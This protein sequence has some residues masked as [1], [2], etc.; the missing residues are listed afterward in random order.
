MGGILLAQPVVPAGGVVD[1]AAYSRE[2]APG[3]IVTIFGANLAPGFAPATELPLPTALAG[4]S[5]EISDGVKTVLMP[6][7]W[8]MPAQLAGQI[9]YDM[10]PHVTFRVLTGAGA[11]DPDSLMLAPRAPKLFSVSEEGVGRAVVLHLDGQGATRQ[12]PLKP[13][14]WV[15]LYANSLG[16]VDPP[17]MAGYGAGDGSPG[18]P[19]SEV[20]APVTAMIGGRPAIVAFAGL[21]PDLAGL[22]QLNVFTPY[23]DTIGD[24][25]V[26]VSAEG[27]ES[28]TGLSVPAEPN[29]FY[30]VIGAGKFPN[31]QTRN[32]VPGPGAAIVFM[33]DNVPIWGEDGLR[34]W[35]FSSPLGA[36]HAATSG[37]ALTL[38]NQGVVV[39]DN[40][41]IEDGTHGGFY[42]NS[43]GAVSDNEK[44]GLWEWY[45]MSNDL[46]GVFASYF[47]LPQ[48]TT[49][50]EIIGYFDGNGQ[51]ELRFN[52][53]SV[54]NRFRMNIWSNGAGEMPATNSFTGNVFSSDATPG[55]FSY[56][57][58]DARRIFSTGAGEPLYRMVYKLDQPL[59]LEAG[60]YWFSHDTAV[61][62]STP[63]AGA[64]TRA[65]AKGY[66]PAPPANAFVGGIE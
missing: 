6:L 21:T 36:A 43:N 52:P 28:Q 46:Y 20:T 17:I 38:R 11:S 44:P 55:I 60:E 19:L 13:G 26:T 9:P 5:V 31:G 58:T 27:V 40:N 18:R 57:A 64:K 3:S 34:Q 25:P 47:R 32:A 65:A 22:Y 45:S 23:Y 4:T 24:L 30:L 50:D 61:P 14:E 29:G 8:V 15:S 7:Y 39:Y 54:Y 35:T 41:G 56:S 37:L 63:V 66:K 53:A 59:T 10:G 49:F 16:E 62:E 1:A 42:D 12:N 51:P 2:A 48:T 33:H